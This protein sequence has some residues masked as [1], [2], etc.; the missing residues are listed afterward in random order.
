[1]ASDCAARGLQGIWAPAGN[2]QLLPLISRSVWT[3]HLR[4]HGWD[5]LLDGD[6][7]ES[8]APNLRKVPVITSHRWDRTWWGFHARASLGLCKQPGP[9]LVIHSDTHPVCSCPHRSRRVGVESHVPLEKLMK[10]KK[11]PVSG[12]WT[13]G[14]DASTAGG[15]S[16][17]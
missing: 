13:H 10:R 14:R 9:Q 15:R 12:S 5:K 8:E 2:V 17:I 6:S 16:W 7:A 4:R 11:R 1:M 3:P